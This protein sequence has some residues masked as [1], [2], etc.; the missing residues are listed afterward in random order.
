MLIIIVLPSIF[1]A[2]KTRLFVF[3]SESFIKKL[4]FRGLVFNFKLLDASFAD[5]VSTITNDFSELDFFFQEL[6]TLVD[7]KSNNLLF[8]RTSLVNFFLDLFI[9]RVKFSSELSLLVKS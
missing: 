3:K 6:S 8:V 5:C 4:L 7:F 2:K 9:I 1:R